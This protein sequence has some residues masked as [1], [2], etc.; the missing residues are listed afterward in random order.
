MVRLRRTSLKNTANKLSMLSSIFSIPALVVWYASQFD[1]IRA[2]LPNHWPPQIFFATVALILVV[3]ALVANAVSHHNSGAEAAEVMSSGNNVAVGPSLPV[4]VATSGAKLAIM[5]REPASAQRKSLS[6]TP[7]T[8][9]LAR[10]E[11]NA[12]SAEAALDFRESL[13]SLVAPF[14]LPVKL[15]CTAK[16]RPIGEL[17]AKILAGIGFELAVNKEDASHIF[18]A[19]PDQPDGILL[20]GPANLINPMMSAL[21]KGLNGMDLSFKV[22]NFPANP[23]YNFIQIEIGDRGTGSQWE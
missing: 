5:P 22:N 4:V 6:A 3:V 23:D 14:R 13:G 11:Y 17:I 9:A 21:Q 10:K 20:R 12:I 1:A 16:G 7:N 18:V 19:R 2:H 8:S 15:I